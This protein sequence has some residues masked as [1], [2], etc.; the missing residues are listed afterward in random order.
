MRRAILNV[1]ILLLAAITLSGCATPARQLMPTPLVCRQPGGLPLFSQ[2]GNQTGST[3]LELLFITDRGPETT[4]EGTLPYGQTRAKR[5]A[6]GSAAVG[7]TPD[8]DW[9]TLREQ[10]QLGKRTREIELA[11][12][13]VKPRS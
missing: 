4:P 9:A 11:L 7:L 6:F 5:L 12:G 13:E 8:I 3:D 10:S 1:S 2:S